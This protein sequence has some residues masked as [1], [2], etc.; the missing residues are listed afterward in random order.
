MQQRESQLTC[1]WWIEAN[2]STS[3]CSLKGIK[4]TQVGPRPIVDLLIGADQADL[5]YSLE[6]VRG[7]PGEPIGRL[8]PLGL[9]CVGNPDVPAERT[10]TNFTFL[11]N[12]TQELSSLV[13][14]YWE[15]E[16]PRETLIINP[17]E[18][19][20]RETVSRSFTFAD[21]HC[22]VSMPW[23]RDRPLLP[24]NY[25]VALNRLQCTEKKLKQCPEL[26]EAYKIKQWFIPI[27]TKDTF[28]KFY[29][30]K[31]SLIKSG[32]YLISQF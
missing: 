21:G 4:L 25:S 9:T 15:I 16:E 12:I 13:R 22:T 32:T 6:D 20:A 5:L 7:K 17:E 27:K 8:T 28:I 29:V 10:Q 3:G 14:R 19:F 26:G 2:T 23:K 31:L 1:K 18:K 24:D 11:L 30:M